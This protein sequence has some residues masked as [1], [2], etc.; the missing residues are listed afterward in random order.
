M[1]ARPANEGHAAAPL[2]SRVGWGAV[3]AL[4]A[5]STLGLARAVSAQTVLRAG[6]NSDILSTDPGTRRDE[7]TDAVL[8]HVV[9]G[10]VATRENLS[11][12]PMLADHWTVSEDGR[13]YT[14]S[15]RRGVVFHNGAPLTSGDVVWSLERYLNPATGWR[16]LAEFTN[17]GIGRIVAV[18]A[19]DPL[20]V[21]VELERPAPLFLA[22]LARADCGGTGITHRD[23]VDPQ[24]HWR[25][26]I[27]TGPFQLTAWRHNEYVE[28]TRFDRY[29]A[30]PGP[31]DGNTGGKHALTD[32]IRFMVIPDS[33]AARAAL[34]R[35]SLDVLDNLAP[36]ELA[37]LRGKPGVRLE[38][39]P[40]LDLYLIRFQTND[41]LLQDERL[42]RAIALTIDTPALAR[43]AT[44]GTGTPDNSPV[45]AASP[46][47]GPAEA[48]L[49]KPDLAEARQLLQ[50][51]GYH[52]QP[53]Q[54]MTNH[55]YPKMFD[56]AVLVQAMAAQIHVNFE[57]Q[58]LDWATQLALYNS[59]AYQAM[60]FAYS[61]RLDPALHFG[62]LIGDKAHNPIKIWDTPRARALLRQSIEAADPATRQAA[63]DALQADFMR[64]VPGIVL[65]NSG[66]I[67]ALRNNVS[68][69]Q[70]W[71]AAQQRLWDVAIR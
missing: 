39:F 7:N 4:L 71:P 65:F 12:G 61:A 13:I 68:G 31:R 70:G 47:Y 16:C 64:E 9:E 30:R 6:L 35:G 56:A 50:E 25:T 27:G 62:A 51:S 66:R 17:G 38:T 60:S 58:T 8:L 10:L 19:P 14:F 41:P 21:V 45:P 54:L 59:G 52:G 49:R 33:S 42:R 57:I 2:C 44:W 3:V 67:T 5:L 32:K 18:T 37:G 22:T 53:I 48:R 69:Y 55:R 11:V 46:F 36:Q 63:F 23:S 1:T 24:G 26:P 28:L 20:T 29:A 40:T 34:L 43:A 15:L